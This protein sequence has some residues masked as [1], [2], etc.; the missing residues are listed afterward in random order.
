MKGLGDRGMP[1]NIAWVGRAEIP[2]ICPP[3]MRRSASADACQQMGQGLARA[4]YASLWLAD[5]PKASLWAMDRWNC[6]G[7][8]ASKGPLHTVA[9][10]PVVMIAQLPGRRV[11]A[12]CIHMQLRAGGKGFQCFPWPL[13]YG[14]VC[15]LR[16]Q[17]WANNAP[18][19]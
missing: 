8:G 14:V 18:C 19:A 4:P 12:A 11:P 16:S 9:G 1:R 7:L 3:H 5:P 2:G 13:A 15:V 6:S 10:Q 17:E